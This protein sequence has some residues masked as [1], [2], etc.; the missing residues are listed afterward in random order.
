MCGIAGIIT[1]NDNFINASLLKSMSDA[2]AHRGPDGEASWVNPTNTAGLAH[3][4]L[5]IIDLSSAAAQPMHYLN[6][7]S[8]VYNG[9]I[10]NYIEL[11]RELNRVGYSFNSS[12]DT[13]VILAA[14][15]FY[16]EKC[17]QYFDGMFAFGIWD[18]KLQQLF[19]ARDRFGEKPFYYYKEDGLFAFA[20]EMK[21]LWAAGVPR[22]IDNKMVLNYLTL[23][24]VQNAGDKSQTFFTGIS[25]LLPSHYLLLNGNTGQFSV[26]NYWDVDKQAVLK[27]TE[28]HA[29]SQF[30]NLLQD[31]V[32]K[33]MRSDVTIGSS[34]SGGLDSSSIAAC[35]IKVLSKK[36]T[37]GKFQTFSAVFPGFE[38]DEQEYINSVVNHFSLENF[39]VS[40]TADDM[41]ND[42][43]KLSY[44]QEEPFPS[45]SIYAQYKVFELAAKHDVKVLL[46]GQG[47]DEVLA[48]YHKYLHW[49]IQELV[50]K[51]RFTEARKERK[52]FASHNMRMQWG[53]KNVLASLLPSHTSIALEKREYQ[54]IAGNGDV[55]KQLL[56]YLKGR[57]WEG[58]HKPIVNKLND[59]L[60]FNTMENGL[61]EM[62]R[63]ADRSSM[64]HGVEVRLP[65]LNAQFV[66][67][68]FSLPSRYKI[69]DGYT[70][71]IL[72]HA[73]NEKLPPAIIWRTDK[74][75]YEPPQKQ[76][77][78]DPLL[79]DYI[80]E[81]KKKLVQENLL[82]PQVLQKK[83]IPLHAH[84][85]HNNDW[86]YLCIAR[87]F[88][89]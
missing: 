73:M 19:A 12:S 53:L 30:N 80:H 16:G 67:F 31:S 59:I 72:R 41:I 13:E 7:Y 37:T 23:G 22:N 39:T 87:M 86:R 75:A 81:A 33:R 6:R 79:V 48:G 58:I 56:G 68:V 76:W 46:D 54:R 61:E 36:K 32:C 47:A 66:Q 43:E 10:Y 57:E 51:N 74:T 50:S 17:L 60:Y 62:L 83:I 77:M 69:R 82:R 15:D 20:S 29:I 44:H 1:Q 3:R 5:A 18:E 21:G 24:Y 78:S 40:P 14:Y 34:L 11:R 26:N 45:S 85:A 42:F 49:Y 35:I 8:I 89:Q 84:E 27:I 88:Q 2:L 71:W 63:F 9:E 70:K 38:K 55:S 64:A 65:F 4:R 25:S 28:P 52:L